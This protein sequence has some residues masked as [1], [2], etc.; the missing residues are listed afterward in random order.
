MTIALV[1]D[2]IFSTRI[3]GT[4][5]KLGVPCRVVRSSEA[6][7]E[8][9][10]AAGPD[11][12]LVLIDLNADGIDATEAIRDVKAQRP[13]LTVIGFLSHVQRELK[14]AAED[15]GADEVLPRSAF[16]ERLPELLASGG[17]SRENA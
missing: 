7:E 8:A 15:A 9:I 5:Q 10:A 4:A 12:P 1:T 2:L 11:E 3:A 6:L 16:V 17:S 13:T 14:R